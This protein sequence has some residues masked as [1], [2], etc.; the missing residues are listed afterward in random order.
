MVLGSSHPVRQ[1]ATRTRHKVECGS[2]FDDRDIFP[3]L[4]DHKIIS[5]NSEID[6]CPVGALRDLQLLRYVESRSVLRL[7]QLS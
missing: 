5:P 2:R 4:T 6:A 1:L 3:R 7:V